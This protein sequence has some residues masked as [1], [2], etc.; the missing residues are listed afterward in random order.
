MP[1][2]E[3]KAPV[4]SFASLRKVDVNEFIEKKNGLS[5]LS[6]AFAV[7]QLL[8]R[9]PSA[10]WEYRFG[11]DP[12]TKESVPFV[13]IGT[14]AMVFCTVRAFG[15]ERTAQ[16][17]IMDHRNKA[18]QDPDAF[19]TNTAM[20]RCLAKAIALHGLGL[21]IYAG[22]DIPPEEEKPEPP[23]P[24][25]TVEEINKAKQILGDAESVDALRG[26]F[27]TMPA[28]LKPILKEYAQALA[29]GLQ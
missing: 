22:E 3:H 24:V 15:V 11:T 19:Q 21:Y 20:Q 25:A 26:L 12:E 6:W 18:I 2:Q 14:T 9:D 23:K 1:E 4:D 17:P 7:D 29:K 10:T 8:Q 27:D 13:Y 28:H 16:L 5:Y